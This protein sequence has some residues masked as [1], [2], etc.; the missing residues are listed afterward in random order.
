MRRESVLAI[1]A[2]FTRGMKGMSLTNDSGAVRSNSPTKDSGAV[3]FNK[4]DKAYV[5]SIYRAQE[6]DADR[7]VR[8]LR[9][10]YRF[11]TFFESAR[12]VRC[13]H[14]W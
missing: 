12:P 3:R 8:N 11:Y 9:L 13:V 2:I 1:P 6:R 5:S 14:C 10:W 4:A 7:P